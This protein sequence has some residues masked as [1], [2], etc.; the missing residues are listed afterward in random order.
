MVVEEN[1]PAIVCGAVRVAFAARRNLA[2]V[3]VERF[4]NS[5]G[6]V[7]VSTVEATVIDLVGYMH[8]AGRL[9][10]VAGVL[11]EFGEDMAPERLVEASK[12]ASIL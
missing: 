6:T 11:S 9:D 12:S 7:V 3:L 4:N 1:R 10:R 5:R 2:A 8:R